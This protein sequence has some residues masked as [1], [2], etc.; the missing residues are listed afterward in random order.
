MTAYNADSITT[1]NVPKVLGVTPE[2][3]LRRLD[4]LGEADPVLKLD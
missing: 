4:Q 1:V 2:A 3:L